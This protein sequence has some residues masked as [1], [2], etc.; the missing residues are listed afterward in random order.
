MGKGTRELQ[1]TE[2]DLPTRQLTQSHLGANLRLEYQY[3][4]RASLYI[5]GVARDT[6]ATDEVPITLRVTTTVQTGYEWHEF[7]EG[8]ANKQVVVEETVQFDQ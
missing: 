4:P 8:I 7:I 3:P 6:V 5:N 2:R 1:E